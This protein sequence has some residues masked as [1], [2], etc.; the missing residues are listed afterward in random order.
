VAF[1]PAALL[2]AVA[3]LGTNILAHGDWRTPYAHR[4]VGDNWYDYPGSYWL[5][6]NVR[7]IDRGESSPLVYAFNVLIGH[8]GLFSLTPIWLLSA[9]GCAI[10]VSNRRNTPPAAHHSSDRAILAAFTL[11]TSL[12]VLAF[13]L[14]RPQIDR[15]YGGGTCCLRWLLWLSPLWLLT[16][17]PSADCLGQSRFGRPAAIA[18]LVGSAF[19]AAYAADNPWVHPWIFDYWTAMG[20]IDYK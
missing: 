11:I 16:L 8:H 6:E 7:G 10:W 15:N 5:P 3:A 12:V 1:V 18:L 19:S 20:W 14:S 9:A 2:V 4:G 17:V 13:Y